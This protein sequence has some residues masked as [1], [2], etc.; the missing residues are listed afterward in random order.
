MYS[1]EDVCK[2]MG[3]P[4]VWDFDRTHAD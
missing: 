4:A 3:F 1:F 2:L